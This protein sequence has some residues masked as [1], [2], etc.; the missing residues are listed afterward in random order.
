MKESALSIDCWLG[1]CV[2]CLLGRMDGGN[3]DL[4]RS[5][6]IDCRDEVSSDQRYRT[7]TQ[8]RSLNVVLS[9]LA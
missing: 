9:H 2:D 5:I 6:C 4:K 7:S 3:R 1:E 8:N